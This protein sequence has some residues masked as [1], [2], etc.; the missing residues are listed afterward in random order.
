LP[1]KRNKVTAASTALT[2]LE[3]AVADRHRD[4]YVLRLYIVGT[5][6]SSMRAV[7]NIRKVCEEHLMGRYDLE[8]IDVSRHPIL[9]ADEQII[10]VPTLIKKLPLPLRRFIGDLS[11]TSRILV[12]LD[13]RSANDT[14]PSA[15]QVPDDNGS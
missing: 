8:V 6:P 3:K 1:A 9:A 2:A 12:G 11:E 15:R 14:G 4:H 5:T 10:A 7:A 13:L